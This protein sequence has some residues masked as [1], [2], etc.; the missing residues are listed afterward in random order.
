MAWA[1]EIERWA[2]ASKE[3]VRPSSVR[4]IFLLPGARCTIQRR[5]DV[6][7][8]PQ[9][10]V[11]TTGQTN[12]SQTGQE[13]KRCCCPIT[14]VGRSG[15]WRMFLAGLR[16]AQPKG[17]VEGWRI[18]WGAS[19]SRP[20][21]KNM[22]QPRPVQAQWGSMICTEWL[23]AFAATPQ[24]F[25]LET[26]GSGPPADATPPSRKREGTVSTRNSTTLCYHQH[27]AYRVA[28]AGS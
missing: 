9:V 3:P 25:L 10:A 13:S 28:L 26:I 15:H 7:H 11:P 18:H 19:R 4:C 20:R 21:R 2:G 12:K 6:R 22:L 27:A 8:D 16:L 1:C 24:P 5:I 17:E 23:L 14:C